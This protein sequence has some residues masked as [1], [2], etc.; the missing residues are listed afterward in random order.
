MGFGAGSGYGWISS[1]LSPTLNEGKWPKILTPCWKGHAWWGGHCWHFQHVIIKSHTVTAIQ[2]AFPSYSNS[3]GACVHNSA[4]FLQFCLASCFMSSCVSQLPRCP[5]PLI[6]VSFLFRPLFCSSSLIRCFL[7][8]LFQLLHCNRWKKL[9]MFI[10]DSRY[11]PLEFFPSFFFASNQHLLRRA[12][13]ERQLSA[14]NSASC[15]S[16]HKN[17]STKVGLTQ[18]LIWWNLFLSVQ[19]MSH[20]TLITLSL[21]AYRSAPQVIGSITRSPLNSE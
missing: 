17:R 10:P 3:R 18:E 16:S 8:H 1:T 9:F 5:P 2:S 21:S 13:W 4:M 15:W 6:H 12:A 20:W 7:L 19:I 11:L 14:H